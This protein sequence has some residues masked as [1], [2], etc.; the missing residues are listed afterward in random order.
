MINIVVETIKYTTRISNNEYY[1]VTLVGQ[2]AQTI[3][4][5]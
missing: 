4:D 3:Q 2:M 1:D 5:Y